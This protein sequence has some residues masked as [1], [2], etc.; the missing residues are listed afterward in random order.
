VG[1]RLYA[2][3]G[4]SGKTFLDTTEYLDP[5]TMEWTNFTPK[6]EGYKSKVVFN[7]HHLRPPSFEDPASEDSSRTSPVEHPADEALEDLAQDSCSPEEDLVGSSAFEEVKG[8]FMSANV[9]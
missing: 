7:G 5:D 2:V 9:H 6:P 8:R 1:G 3:G 4:F